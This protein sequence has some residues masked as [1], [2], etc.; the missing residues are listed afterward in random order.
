MRYARG[1]LVGDVVTWCSSRLV[2]PD[3]EIPFAFSADVPM[4][5][6]AEGTLVIVNDDGTGDKKCIYYSD[7]TTWRK[8][9]T[10]NPD[11]GLVIPET[12]RPVPEA[13]TVYA[14]NPAT[15]GYAI[16]SEVP[17]PSDGNTQGFGTFAAYSGTTVFSGVLTVQCKLLTSNPAALA[18]LIAVLRRVKPVNFTL[19][20]KVTNLDDEILT[21]TIADAREAA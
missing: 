20:L 16:T 11:L 10:T 8:N 6:A 12:A 21:F 4:A 14:P 3:F 5:I 1:Y 13:I 18:T 7:G 2:A 17:P 19:I 9:S 15:A